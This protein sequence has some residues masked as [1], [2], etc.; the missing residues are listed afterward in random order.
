LEYSL[1]AGEDP[2]AV[3][4]MRLCADNQ[5]ALSDA[6]QWFTATFRS[7]LQGAVT[8]GIALYN[9]AADPDFSQPDTTPPKPSPPMPAHDPAPEGWS[10]VEFW[11]AP[12][13]EDDNDE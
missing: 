1:S 3:V 2:T 10:V 13:N 9:G 4:R 12:T 11:N 7:A 8:L 5:A 6:M